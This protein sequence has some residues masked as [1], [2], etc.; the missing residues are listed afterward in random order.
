MNNPLLDTLRRQIDRFEGAGHKEGLAS[1]SSGC[2]PLD[3]LLPKRGFCRGALV[4]WLADGEAA[5]A[6]TLAMTAARQAC[7]D[8]GALIVLDDRCEFYPPA[9]ARLGIELE[10]LIVVQARGRA[11]CAWALDQALRCRAV[12]AV[13]ARLDK[14]DG[15]AFRRLQ[16]AAEQSGAIGMIIRPQ[17]ARHEPAWTDAR[18]LV[19]LLALGDSVAGRRLRIHLLR[20]RGRSGG[21]NVDVEIDDETHTMHLVTQLADCSARRRFALDR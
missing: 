12:A 2:G 4:E 7:L 15:R 10:N 19:E 6:M 8:G 3:G 1:V 16:L 5:G 13:V 14:F 9:A 11:D 21:D 20:C 18:I 17:T